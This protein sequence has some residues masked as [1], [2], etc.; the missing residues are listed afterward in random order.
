MYT[1]IK[2]VK[3]QQFLLAGITSHQ[4]TTKIPGRQLTEQVA[5]RKRIIMKITGR[6]IENEDEGHYCAVSEASCKHFNLIISNITFKSFSISHRTL[7]PITY[8]IIYLCI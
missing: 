1:R 3:I 6:R 2:C 5:A 8:N 7:F 4:E